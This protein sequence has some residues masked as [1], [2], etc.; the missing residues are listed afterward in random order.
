MVLDVFCSNLQLKVSSLYMNYFSIASEETLA[1]IHSQWKEK[2]IWLHQM[3]V[4]RFNMKFP[5]GSY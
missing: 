3:F 2:Q 1:Q 4:L 5:S